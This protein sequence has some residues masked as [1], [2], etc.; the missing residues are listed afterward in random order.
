MRGSADRSGDRRVTL[1]EAYAYAHAR[2]VADTADTAAGA[3][4]PTFAFDLKG[5]GDLVLTDL[6]SQRE[7]LIVPGAAP[8][9]TY[10]VVDAAAGLIVTEVDKPA[11]VD[12]QIA[13]APGWYRIK[14]RLPDRLRLGEVAIA[15]GR[16]TLLD[17]ARLRDAPFADDP[18]KGVRRELPSR[19]HLGVTG[20][21]QSFLDQATRA[22]LFPSTGML[23]LDLAVRDYFRQ[24]WTW[25]LDLAFGS[26]HG[27]LVRDGIGVPLPYEMTELG[28]GLSLY[29]EWPILDGRLTPF[30]GG[31]L[32]FLLLGRAFE[33][34]GATVPKQ[35]FA[36]FSPGIVAGLRAEL[37]AGF[38]FAARGRVHYVLY[39]LAEQSRSLAYLEL[40]GQLGYEF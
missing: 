8:A 9:G 34:A 29:R 23:G 28:A 30:A 37:P 40:G 35:A 36:T 39:N 20:A 33:G 32:A 10:Y 7:G 15:P 6:A 31:R 27:E 5:N 1:S 25:G 26:T 13:L 16:L 14:R 38:A 2:T 22:S 19:L 21:F 4:H 3:Q 12:R 17:E 24:R 11:G 18:V